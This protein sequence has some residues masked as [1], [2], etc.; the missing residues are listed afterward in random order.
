MRQCAAQAPPVFQTPPLTSVLM[1]FKIK[2]IKRGEC[3]FLNFNDLM[4]KSFVACLHKTLCRM[5]AD[6]IVHF[7]STESI[8][9]KPTESL[10]EKAFRSNGVRVS[11]SRLHTWTKLYPTKRRFRLTSSLLSSTPDSLRRFQTSLQETTRHYG[12]STDRCRSRAP[13]S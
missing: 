11:T 7:L 12:I 2:K 9:R 13:Y 8:Q 6:N 3:S 10:V 5:I 1:I 4:E